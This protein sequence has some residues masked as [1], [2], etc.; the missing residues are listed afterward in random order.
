MQDGTALFGFVSAQTHVCIAVT[1]ICMCPIV[2]RQAIGKV[3]LQVWIV[4]ICLLCS[5]LALLCSACICVGFL[6]CLHGAHLQC[7]KLIGLGQKL[8]VGVNRPPM[9]LQQRRGAALQK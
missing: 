4:I 9:H 6:A 2:L 5:V 3:C 1:R 8:E 7:H